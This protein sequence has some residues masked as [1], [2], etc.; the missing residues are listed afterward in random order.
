MTISA[1]CANETHFLRSRSTGKERDTE[2]GNDYFKYRY[3]ASSMGR[4]LSPDPSGL[5]H[6]DLGNPQSLNLY[7][8]V[9]N[10]PLTV[11]DLDGLCWK[12]FQWACDLGNAIKSLAIDAKN[13]I[14]YGE[15]TTNTTQAK[16]HSVDR[17]EAKARRNSYR[18]ETQFVPDPDDDRPGL[19]A[20]VKGVARNTAGFPDVCSGG[21]FFV[22]G[23][24]VSAGAARGEGGVITE[25]DSKDGTS[26][27]GL[28]E[29]SGGEGATAGGGA[30]VST[31]GV[32]GFG[33]VGAE[34][35]I[36]VGEAG[37]GVVGFSSG[38]VG[39]YAQGGAFGRFNEAGAY[40]N[41]ST[42]GGCAQHK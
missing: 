36:G 16:I 2:S 38:G 29:G 39:V 12:G 27:G 11:A 31:G 19:T 13:K 40:V 32:E 30:I 7:N 15:W 14:A 35:D 24:E 20:M 37:A 10:R 42:M 18:K 28:A 17:H 21:V 23:G 1:V 6:A 25:V 26:V 41:V 34:A 8:Y 22:K 33:F 9:G 3:Y 4:W 5:S